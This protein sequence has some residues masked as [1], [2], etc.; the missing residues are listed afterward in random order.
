MEYGLMGR[1]TIALRETRHSAT[2]WRKEI[3]IYSLQVATVLDV[4]LITG[5][6]RGRVP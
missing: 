4:A 5:P 2:D 3:S 6:A 1:S